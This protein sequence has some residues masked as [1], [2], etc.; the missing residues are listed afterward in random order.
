M[1]NRKLI[2]KSRSLSMGLD[3]DRKTSFALVMDSETGEILAE[4][5]SIPTSL[6]GDNRRYW[7]SHVKGEKR[8]ILKSIQLTANIYYTNRL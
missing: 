8:L 1:S 6:P 3:V 5:G 2:A 4:D 7:E